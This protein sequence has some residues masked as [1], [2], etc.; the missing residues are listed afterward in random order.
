MW[1]NFN[2]ENGLTWKVSL[3]RKLNG[4]TDEKYKTLDLYGPKQIVL[5]HHAL[6]LAR[7]FVDHRHFEV[8]Y[9]DRMGEGLKKK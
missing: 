2:E 1:K 9:G 7:Q 6:W 4:E 5:A 8:F 3:S